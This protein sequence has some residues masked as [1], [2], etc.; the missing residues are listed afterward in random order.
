MTGR[1]APAAII[2]MISLRP[3]IEVIIGTFQPIFLAPA[4]AEMVSR[5]M[6]ARTTRSHLALRRLASCEERSTEPGLKP[7]RAAIFILLSA[8][9]SAVPF[10]TSLP[11][12][13]SW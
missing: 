11:K 3:G 12:A 4:T 1:L 10:C 5:T 13:S 2:V 8:S 7:A 6:V 9:A